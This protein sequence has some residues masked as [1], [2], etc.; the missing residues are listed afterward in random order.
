MQYSTKRRLLGDEWQMQ[1]TCPPPRVI[2]LM[3]INL[4]RATP[5]AVSEAEQPGPLLT[6]L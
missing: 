1:Y 2:L 6:P 4:G 5:A 3:N